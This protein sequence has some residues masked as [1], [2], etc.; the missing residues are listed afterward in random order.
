M[1]FLIFQNGLIQRG[2]PQARQPVNSNYIQKSSFPDWQFP[3]LKVSELYGSV[4]KVDSPDGF[5][6]FPND[7]HIGHQ[8]IPKFPPQ[9]NLVQGVDFSCQ[10]WQ[11]QNYPY[12][13]Y[14]RRSR[15]L[16]GRSDP[17]VS[18][19]PVNLPSRNNSR[20]PDILD[21]P[22]SRSKSSSSSKILVKFVFF[23]YKIKCLI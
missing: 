16:P 12:W 2:K 1:T 23:F 22:G 19:G 5:P 17:N 7:N 9:N 10:V 20:L 13:Q 6:Y 15:P 3:D 21:G 11:R 4:V 14:N 8:N 18:D